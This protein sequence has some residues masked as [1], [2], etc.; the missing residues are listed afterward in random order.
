MKIILLFSLTHLKP[1]ID[2]PWST[3]RRILDDDKSGMGNEALL[4]QRRV[5]PA[6]HMQP[7]L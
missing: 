3:K 4:E 1:K 6:S 7:L 2:E 5:E